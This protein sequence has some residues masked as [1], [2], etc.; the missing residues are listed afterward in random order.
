MPIAEIDGLKISYETRGEGPPLVFLH[1]WTGNKSFFFKQVERFSRD[2]RCI[3]MDFPGHGES[4]ACDEYSVE[5]FGELTVGLLKQ[6]G[7]RKAV[8]AGHSMGGM[9]SMYLALEHPDMV[10]GLILIDTTPHLAG[11]FPQ[12]IASAVAVA[13]GHLGFKTGRGFV[14][15]IAATHP[16]ASPRS[17]C[18]TAREC[19]KV[20]NRV[21]VKTLDRARKYDVTKLLGAITQPSLIVVGT[22]D[23]L[24]DLRHARKMA[25]EIP[26]STM[27]IVR[28]AGHMAL[29]EKPEVVNRAMEDFLN[30]VY[31][32][33]A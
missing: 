16:L 21:V 24:A 18:I 29:F 4:G 17:R 23:L 28:G 27:K 13:L 6:L 5:R 20:P 22:A 33:A 15:G 14:A 8:F 32:P 9:V 12:N 7:I 2:Y 25:K 3:C 11:W 10:E 1:C 19:S 26:D 30:R 31:P